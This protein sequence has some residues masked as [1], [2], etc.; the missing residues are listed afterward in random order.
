MGQ[1]LN[2]LIAAFVGGCV[3]ERFRMCAIKPA[4][5]RRNFSGQFCGHLVLRI[6]YYLVYRVRHVSS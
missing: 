5:K 1:R 4:L 2:R 6:R 3:P